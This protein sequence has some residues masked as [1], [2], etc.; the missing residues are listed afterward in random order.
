MKKNRYRL[1]VLDEQLASDRTEY[2]AHC[3]KSEYH[4][5]VTS[6]VDS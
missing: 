4:V 2:H 6:L 1:Q 3:D 5:T